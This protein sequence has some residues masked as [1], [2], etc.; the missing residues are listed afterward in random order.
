MTLARRGVAES[1]ELH[2]A[3]ITAGDVV[4]LGVVPA[5]Q[6]RTPG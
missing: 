4:H 2:A 3:T 1:V 5:R 6:W